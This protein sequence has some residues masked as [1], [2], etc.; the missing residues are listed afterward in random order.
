L[1]KQPFTQWINKFGRRSR[2]QISCIAANAAI[3]EDPKFWNW[4]QGNAQ[5]VYTEGYGFLMKGYPAFA[6]ETD[7]MTQTLSAIPDTLKDFHKHSGLVKRAQSV[8]Q[9]I[10]PDDWEGTEELILD[11]WEI[12]GIYIAD[13]YFKYDEYYPLVKDAE[14]IGV[15]VYKMNTVDGTMKAIRR[16]IGD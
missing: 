6:A 2:D 5:S 13:Y 14:S 1:P 3:G 7:M 15:P 9:G 16:Y 12:I 4:D 10:N 8:T 11:N